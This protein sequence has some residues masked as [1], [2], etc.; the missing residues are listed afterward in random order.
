[1]ELI[2][3]HITLFAILL[4]VFGCGDDSVKVEPIK[5]SEKK[6]LKDFYPNGSL[7]SEVIVKDDMYDGEAKQYYEN[8]ALANKATFKN[9]VRVGV[10][11]VYYRTGIL[12]LKENYNEKGELEGVFEE[13]FENEKIK[14]TGSY[15]QNN[16]TGIWKE[17]FE[18]GTLYEENTLSLNEFNGEQKVYHRNGKLA[19]KGKAING[20]EEG[21][22]LF[23]DVNGDTL[24]IETYQAGEIM[25]VK[26]YKESEKVVE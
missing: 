19:V 23:L 8:G 12:K 15:S 21:D 6:V 9:D 16:R 25:S 5:G 2:K 22:W 1:M 10:N 4:I 18:D 20:K 24:K 3:K 7:K 11:L 17:F 14:V 13:Y 26:K